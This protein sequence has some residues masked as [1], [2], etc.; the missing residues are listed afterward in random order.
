[1]LNYE[2]KHDIAASVVSLEFLPRIAELGRWWRAGTFYN[3]TVEKITHVT[4]TH[5]GL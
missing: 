4:T 1:M 2:P 3:R 5:A